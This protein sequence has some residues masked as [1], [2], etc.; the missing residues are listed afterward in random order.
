M[1]VGDPRLDEWLFQELLTADTILR[2]R[3]AAVVW[4]APPCLDTSALADHNARL[5][6]FR[7]GPVQRLG[8]TVS[9]VIADLESA[10]CEGERTKEPLYGVSGA[11]PDGIH[12]TAPAAEAVALAF[13]A[14]IV[15]AAG[16]R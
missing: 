9:I 15:A 11:R 13:T 10:Y 16:G 12:L 8:T 7:D 5:D 3:G 4:A 6:R 1:R 2:S 14:P